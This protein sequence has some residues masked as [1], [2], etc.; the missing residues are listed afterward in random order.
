MKT[1]QVRGLDVLSSGN[2]G[3]LAFYSFGSEEAS[4]EELEA[5]RR[6]RRALFERATGVKA[7]T[8]DGK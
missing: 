8:E 2:G 6:D 7:K 4:D 5:Y 3:L 1:K